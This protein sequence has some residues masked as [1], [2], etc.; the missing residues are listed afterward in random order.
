MATACAA[1]V[2][3]RGYIWGPLTGCH[4]GERGADRRPQLAAPTGRWSPIA[5]CCTHRQAPTH[6]RPP[7]P[8]IWPLLGFLI[9]PASTM[10]HDIQDRPR[11]RSSLARLDGWGLGDRMAT[12]LTPS[13]SNVPYSILH[14]LPQSSCWCIRGLRRDPRACKSP[15]ARGRGIAGACRWC[16]GVHFTPWTPHLNALFC[17]GSQIGVYS[18]QPCLHFVVVLS[19]TDI[20]N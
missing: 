10:I 17:S 13:F 8:L 15:S 9:L 7:R 18:A 2:L 12:A 1:P 6:T 5:R 16:P 19:L 20:S 4:C 11:L 3:R 14:T